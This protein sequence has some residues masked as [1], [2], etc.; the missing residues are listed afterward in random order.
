MPTGDEL[1][2]AHGAVRWRT[3]LDDRQRDELAKSNA[4]EV[5][6]RRVAHARRPRLDAVAA[7]VR[8]DMGKLE[9]ALDDVKKLA[10]V[11]RSKIDAFEQLGDTARA[12]RLKA[13]ATELETFA[14]PPAS[15]QRGDARRDAWREPLPN[16]EHRGSR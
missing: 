2:N 3:D 8:A 11:V 7:T 1:R 16:A 5:A 6:E 12:V 9:V 14:E 13:I 4:R 10:D 15:S